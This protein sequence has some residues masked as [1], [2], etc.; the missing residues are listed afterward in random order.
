ML[1]RVSTALCLIALAGTLVAC[2]GDEEE[3][4]SPPGQATSEAETTTPVG[5]GETG[6]CSAEEEVS[7][8][9]FGDHKD[10]DFTPT[11]FETNPPAGGDHNPTPLGGGQFYPRPPPLGEAVHLLEHGAVIGWTND[12][13][14]ADQ[15]AVEDEFNEVFGKGY[16]Q[17]AVVENPGLEVPFA[18]S[19]W[20]FLQSCE[21]ADAS[22]IAPFVEEHYA[23]PTSG[24]SSLACQGE[25]RRV[26]ACKALQ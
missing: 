11:D 17:L 9:D 24:E 19:A 10:R 5:E 3:T 26:P 12:L 15:K 25:A 6:S 1:R 2:G 7:V 14:P 18:L 13:D 23:P 21:E 16:Y 4:T 22:V 8:A 20:G